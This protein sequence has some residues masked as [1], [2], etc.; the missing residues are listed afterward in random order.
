[1]NCYGLKYLINLS[2]RSVIF[3]RL[4]LKKKIILLFL[5]AMILTVAFFAFYFYRSTRELLSESEHNLEVIVTNSIAQEIQDNLDYTEANV[6]TVVENPKVQELFAN[7]DRTGLYEYLRPTYDSMKDQFPQGHFHLPDSTSFLRLNKPEKYGDS[8]KDFRF[9]VNE[10]NRSHKTVKGIEGGVSGFGFRVVMPVSYQGNHIGSFEFGKEMEKS[11]LEN[12]KQ[13]YNGDFTLYKLEDDAFTFI[14]STI[15]EEEIPFPY[16]KH[17]EQLKNGE[18]FFV[19]SEDKHHNYYFLPLKSYDDKTLGVLQFTEDRTE[20]VAR[21]QKVFKNLWLVVILMLLILPTLAMILLTRAFKPLHALVSDAEVIARGDFTKTFETNRKDEIGMLSNSLNNIS[22]GLKNMFH[23][24][25]DMSSEVA[26]TSSEISAS[27][28]ELT[29]FNQEVHQNVIDV[30][31]LASDQLS[32]LDEAKA[33]V[34]Y[35][36]DRIF[37][38]NESVKRINESMESVINSTGEGTD[39]SAKI[40]ERILDLQETSEKTNF[41]I[42][43]LSEGSIEIEEIINTIRGIAEETNMLALNASIEAAR[44]GEAGRGLSVV[45]SE[46][47]KLAEQSKNSTNSIDALIRDIRENIDSVVSSTLENNEK[48]EEGV[49]VVQESKATF[50]VINSEVQAIVTQVTDITDM[51][52]RIYEKIE[53][54]LNG[55]HDIVEKSDNTMSHIDSVKRISEDQTSAMNEIT[56]S[57]IALAEMSIELKDAVSKFKY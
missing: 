29:A 5:L 39:A 52:G 56:N 36:A 55:F 45:A 9:T 6:R 13:S 21:E 11:F 25:G 31:E 23:V 38:L 18:S 2:Q 37:E 16:P 12:M 26:N 14:S 54:L 1:M 3:M 27:S 15:S 49:S 53:T 24:I 20:I 19:T 22:S 17:L 35:M 57:T 44:A 34:Q 50:G 28:Q 40:E 42:K 47:S 4:S 43:K 30:S 7:R 32:S 33:N 41:K 51:V 8:L 48:L 46:V 10:A